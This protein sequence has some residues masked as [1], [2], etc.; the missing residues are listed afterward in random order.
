VLARYNK[1]ARRLAAVIAVALVD[2]HAAFTAKDVDEFL[3]DG[4]QPNAEGHQ[5]I[6][7]LLVPV[8]RQQ[9]R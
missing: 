5:L 3:L 8:I 7:E 9:L 1:A 4:M 2:V 6:A